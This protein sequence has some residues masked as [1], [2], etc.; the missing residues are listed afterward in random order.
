MRRYFKHWSQPPRRWL[1]H[2]HIPT[3]SA[4]SRRLPNCHRICQTCQG[5]EFFMG[6]IASS[7]LV[8]IL[9]QL[10]AHALS[11]WCPCSVNLV[12]ML[13]QLG[14]HALST[15]CSCSVNLVLMLCQL[16]AHALSTGPPM[17]CQL[18]PMLCQLVLYV[19][20]QHVWVFTELREF[21]GQPV[22]DTSIVS[23]SSHN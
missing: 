18:V 22:C 7:N 20:H 1:S 11:T 17:V 12:L 14:A 4:A 3:Q 15:W 8:L 6:S 9:C 23:R 10:G 5:P 19:S 13:C 16:G 21:T 2:R